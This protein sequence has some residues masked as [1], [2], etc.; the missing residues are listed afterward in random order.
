VTYLECTILE[1]SLEVDRM[2]SENDFVK[3]RMVRSI[4]HVT[5]SEFFRLVESSKRVSC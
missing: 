3:V 2:T 1:R 4:D 5:I